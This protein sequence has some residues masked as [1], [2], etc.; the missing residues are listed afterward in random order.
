MEKRQRSQQ[1]I[2]GKLDGNMQKSQTG[3]LSYIIHKTKFKMGERP[4]CE[5]GNHQNPREEHRQQPFWPSFGKEELKLSLLIKC[6]IYRKS[7]KNPL[8]NCNN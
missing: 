3:P 1:M 5:T 2:L 7:Q 8:K 6:F 4:N